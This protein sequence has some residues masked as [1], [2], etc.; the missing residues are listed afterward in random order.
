[1]FFNNYIPFSKS[2][3]DTDIAP[4]GIAFYFKIEILGNT[5]YFK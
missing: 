5:I 1:M 4:I 2:H 3:T